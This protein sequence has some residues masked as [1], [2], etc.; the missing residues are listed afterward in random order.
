MHS[1]YISCAI[2]Y[3]FTLHK[4]H[5]ADIFFVVLFN[6]ARLIPHCNNHIH[7]THWPRDG[8]LLIM[9]PSSLKVYLPIPKYTCKPRIL[10]RDDFF[11][12][13]KLTKPIIKKEASGSC[14]IIV[15]HETN[16]A[17]LLNLLFMVNITSCLLHI[18]ERC[19]IKSI[20]TELNGAV[21]IG[22][23]YNV[24]IGACVSYLLV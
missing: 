1:G 11:E 6:S 22:S 8:V 4:A 24:P 2:E 13:P 16:Y 17:Y 21:G 3:I 23:S 19:I 20:V 9:L 15:M 5:V 14:C 10:I 18:M 12:H 7:F